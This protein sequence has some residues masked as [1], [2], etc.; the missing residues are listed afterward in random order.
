MQITVPKPDHV[1]AS[2]VRDFDYRDFPGHD[3]DVQ[4]AWKQLHDGPD[5]FWSIG[6]ADSADCGRGTLRTRNVMRRKT[7]GIS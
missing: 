1:P 2:L 4:L 3:R 7:R 6:W 5:I